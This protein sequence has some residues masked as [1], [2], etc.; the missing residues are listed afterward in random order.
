[1]TNEQ[2][3]AERIIKELRDEGLTFGDILRV[4]RA[5]EFRFKDLMR[6][7]R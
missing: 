7:K 3:I 1:M 5:I 6:V 2:K 4:V